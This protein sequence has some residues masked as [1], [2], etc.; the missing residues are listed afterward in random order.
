MSLYYRVYLACCVLALSLCKGLA[1]PALS[2]AKAWVATFLVH[3]L[4]KRGQLLWLSSSCCFVAECSR[5]SASHMDACTSTL[6]RPHR[7]R[8]CSRCTGGCLHTSTILILSDYF[9]APSILSPSWPK[10]AF[11]Q[12]FVLTKTC[13]P[14]LLC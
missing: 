9:A 10:R 3:F 4:S 12:S 14:S 11:N 5:R 6:F 8:R 2:L 1:L 7:N 13:P